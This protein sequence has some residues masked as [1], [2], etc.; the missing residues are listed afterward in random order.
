M[1]KNNKKTDTLTENKSV[2]KLP[3]LIKDPKWYQLLIS[4]RGTSFRISMTKKLDDI[5][6]PSLGF[7]IWK[8][9]FLY[10]EKNIPKKEIV[11]ISR[12]MEEA[13]AFELQEQTDF[14]KNAINEKGFE[15][16]MLKTEIQLYENILKETE[17]AIK[18][19]KDDKAEV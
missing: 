5:F 4:N 13:L 6:T 3:E 1:S 12:A 9:R 18:I 8:N 17:K 15:I 10:P 7:Q 14:I 16:S 2:S 19:Y 11:T